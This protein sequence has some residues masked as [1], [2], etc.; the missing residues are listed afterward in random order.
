M[1]SKT[2]RSFEI[3]IS[4]LANG[5]NT[6]EY[7]L[8][9]EFFE[10]FEHSLIE[11]G[12]GKAFLDV[13]KSE[14]MMQLSFRIDL[15]IE[16]ECDISLKKFDHQI[17]VENELIIKFGPEEKE[18]SEDVIVIRSDAQFF[19]VAGYIYEFCSLEV[20]MKSIHPDI[21]AQE[22][23]DLYYGTPEEEETEV[24]EEIDPRWAALKKLKE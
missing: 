7:Q 9:N 17:E 20:P 23:P 1:D 16:M 15:T 18:L 24:S 11:K 13:V 21:E 14:T 19:N 6:F 4:R 8:N 2:L 12:K 5:S 3:M 22:R 10:H